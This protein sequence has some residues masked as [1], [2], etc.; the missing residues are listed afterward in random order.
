M[1]ITS[2][3]MV[4]RSLD[5]LQTRLQAY[6]RA[7]SELGTGRRILRPSDDPAGSRR[8]MSLGSAL[9]AREQDLRNASDAQGW[10]DTADSALQSALE[11]LS[12]VRELALRGAS[13]SG[14]AE[15]QALAAEV[16]EIAEEL[17]GIANTRHVDRPLFGGF[18]DGDAV[19]WDGTEWVF[20]GTGEQITRRVSDS[21]LVRVNVTAGEWL[22]TGAGTG[23]LLGLL[24]QLATDLEAGTADQVGARVG[25]LKAA[26]DRI[27]S[28]LGQIGAATNRVESA[29]ERATDLTLTLRTELSSVQDVDLAAGMMELQVQQ[30]AYEATLQALAKALPPSLVAFLR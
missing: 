28:A 18:S 2:E 15:R 6:E 24:E 10:L 30:V 21:E 1:R 3:V 8:A 5:R 14:A 26:S 7:Q 29:R 12:R 16:R 4:T 20:A 27:T 19:T 25:D 23:N 13:D 17:Q 9:R 11:R 22:G